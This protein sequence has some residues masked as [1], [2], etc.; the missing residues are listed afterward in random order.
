MSV[1]NPRWAATAAC[2]D[3][4]SR[5]PDDGSGRLRALDGIINEERYMNKKAKRHSETK[6]SK[7][8]FKRE[9]VRAL[10][11]DEAARIVGGRICLPDSC[12]GRTTVDETM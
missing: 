7:L 10:S 12:G 8:S 5:S 1:R 11:A 9:T 4:Q 6:G 2:V 3:L